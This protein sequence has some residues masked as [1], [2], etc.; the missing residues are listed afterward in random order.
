MNWKKWVDK[1]DLK[2]LRTGREQAGRLLQS[3]EEQLGSG[4]CLDLSSADSRRPSTIC[5]RSDARGCTRASM[6]ARTQ[7]RDEHWSAA[8]SYS[9]WRA[10]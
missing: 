6:N 5:A 7:K 10:G 4:N 1:S 3:A 8:G 9:M 2:P